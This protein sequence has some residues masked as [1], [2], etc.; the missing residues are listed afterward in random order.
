MMMTETTTVAAKPLIVTTTV[1]TEVIAAV[2]A[3]AIDRCRVN[4]NAAIGRITAAKVTTVA[5]DATI[6]DPVPIKRGL[7]VTSAVSPTKVAVSIAVV[8]RNSKS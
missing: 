8:Q 1:A 7:T 3:A 2:I 5:V 4:L 6:T